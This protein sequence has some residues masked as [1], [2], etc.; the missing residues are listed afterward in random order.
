MWDKDDE[1]TNNNLMYLESDDFGLRQNVLFKDVMT[2]VQI[3]TSRYIK[4]TST[5]LKEIN[6][7]PNSAAD[8]ALPTEIQ[9]EGGRD[10]Y[11]IYGRSMLCRRFGVSLMNVEAVMDH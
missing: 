7:P 3:I 6:R 1:V 9:D 2:G 11:R 5:I 10:L 8:E 4:C